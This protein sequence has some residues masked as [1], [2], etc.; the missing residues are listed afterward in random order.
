MANPILCGRDKTQKGTYVLADMLEKYDSKV[1]N[2]NHPLQRR[3]GRWP[4][5][6]KSGLI[7]TVLKNEDIDPIKLCEQIFDDKYE[8]WLIDGLQRLTVLQDYKNNVFSIASDQAFPLVYY[9]DEKTGEIVEYDIRKKSYSQLPKE[10]QKKFNGYNIEVVKHLDC[11]NKEIA[12]HMVRYNNNCSMNVNEKNFTYM[13]NMA[14]SIKNL[15][16]NNRFFKDCGDYK[17]PERRKG[18][19]ER[20]IMESMMLL[21]HF[22]CWSKGKKMNLYLDE[23]ASDAEIGIFESEINRLSKFIDKP[24]TGQLFNSKN[25]FIWFGA[26]H[27]FTEYGLEDAKFAEFLTAFQSNLHTKTFAEYE[28]ES[29]DTYDNGKGT[30]DKKVVAAKLDMLEKLMKEYYGLS[31]QSSEEANLEVENAEENITVRIGQEKTPIEEVS[32]VEENSEVVTV[33]ETLVP[34]A[35]EI[36][37]QKTLDFAQAEVDP[38]IEMEDIEMYKAFLDDYVKI[39]STVNSVG[40]TVLVSLLAYAFKIDKD[41]EFSEW[42]EK[43]GK[44]E[45]SYSPNDRINFIYLKREFDTYLDGLN[46]KTAA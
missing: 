45:R 44:K 2:P 27:K 8:L 42:L 1:F 46:G 35:D 11:T 32:K 26:F 6:Y 22:D 37:N 17:E 23:N 14:E 24:T 12:Y 34:T 40:S 5:D 41:N 18:V 7:A 25:S 43:V 21:F 20:V 15:S 29:F 19:V 38:A 33:E 3:S 4:K 36:E 16:K 9:K 28:G 39:D 30:K 13:L 31:D 10:L